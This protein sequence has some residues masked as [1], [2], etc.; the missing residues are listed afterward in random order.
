MNIL[1]S[2]RREAESKAGNDPAHDLGHIL[3][4]YK[5]AQKICRDENA[6]EAL[7]LIA[8]LLH[9]IVSFPKSDRRSKLSATKSAQ[10]SQKILARYNFTSAE[11]KI[12]CDAIRDHS[13]SSGRTPR[14]ME[15]KILVTDHVTPN[16]QHG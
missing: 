16:F 5:N 2:I 1:E 13:F 12:I 7:V 15:G 14:T 9:D 8:V 10:E 11:I 3:R 4:V 6:D